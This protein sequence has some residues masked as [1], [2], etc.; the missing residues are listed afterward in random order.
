MS[1]LIMHDR[2]EQLTAV[3]FSAPRPRVAVAIEN[4]TRR[5]T[6]H[7]RDRHVGNFND[8]RVSSPL[9]ADGNRKGDFVALGFHAGLKHPHIPREPGHM[10]NGVTLL[11]RESVFAIER[12]MTD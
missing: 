6:S 5:V 4:H 9:D 2:A 10:V 8:R 12:G 7:A 3:S 1:S 11:A